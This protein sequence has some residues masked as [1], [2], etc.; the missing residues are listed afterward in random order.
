MIK[1]LKLTKNIHELYVFS[2]ERRIDEDGI[3]L[4]S[5]SDSRYT[6]YDLE[7]ALPPGTLVELSLIPTQVYC[8]LAPSAQGRQNDDNAF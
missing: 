7:D 3:R 8:D 6:G 2:F 4:L 1:H 5:H